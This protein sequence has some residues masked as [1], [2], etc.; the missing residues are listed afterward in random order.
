MLFKVF[1]LCFNWDMMAKSTN[2]RVS[3]VFDIFYMNLN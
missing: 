1:D 3:F 2:N